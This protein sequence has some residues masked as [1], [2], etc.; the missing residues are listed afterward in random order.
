ML[1]KYKKDLI[2]NK[3]NLQQ[4]IR[5]TTTTTAITSTK[6]RDAYYL[7]LLNILKSKSIITSIQELHSI[8]EII[9][10]TFCCSSSTSSMESIPFELLWELLLKY[11][12]FLDDK[13][14]MEVY[15]EYSSYYKQLIR[16]LNKS[17]REESILKKTR[18][19]KEYKQIEGL[20]AAV[21]DVN[22]KKISSSSRK[23]KKKN[24]ISTI[25]YFFYNYII[26][27]TGKYFIVLFMVGLL[28]MII[29]MKYNSYSSSSSFYFNLKRLL[30]Q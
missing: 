12:Q 24:I 15:S 2:L 14:F 19:Y 16:N 7:L 29:R 1:S 5:D 3:F 9:S 26:R 27:G 25:Y 20:A 13:E 10:T 28:M 8:H 6:Q 17:I 23:N 18:V 11:K 4:F 22:N 30:L 21:V